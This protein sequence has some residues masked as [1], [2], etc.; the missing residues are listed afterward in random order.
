MAI[1]AGYSEDEEDGPAGFA[2]VSV[3]AGFEAVSEAAGL[4][5]SVAPAFASVAGFAL[6]SAG[7]SS[8]EVLDPFDA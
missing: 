3:D 1:E 4:A 7:L 2:A 8:D 5:V 6:V